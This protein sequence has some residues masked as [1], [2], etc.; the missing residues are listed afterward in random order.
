MV[1]AGPGVVSA[2]GDVGGYGF[3]GQALMPVEGA[4]RPGVEL[5]APAQLV[6]PQCP[7][8]RSAQVDGCG[9]GPHGGGEVFRCR[10][11][12]RQIARSVRAVE[13]DHGVNVDGGAFVGR[14]LSPRGVGRRWRRSR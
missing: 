3:V 11:G 6:F 5:G 14:R 7:A 2:L 4:E 10:P 8:V 1:S 12:G 13:A 9:S